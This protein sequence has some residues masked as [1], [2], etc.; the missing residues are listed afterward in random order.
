MSSQAILDYL[1]ANNAVLT[2]GHFVFTSGNH[3]SAYINMRAVAHHSSW[4]ASVGQ[5]LAHRLSKYQPDLILGPETLGR[6]LAG[7][8]AQWICPEGGI[9]CDI[10]DIGN[11]KLGVWRGT[12]GFNQLVEGK[13]V[14]IVD[15]LLTT[16]S[17]IKASSLLVTLSG[18][19][20]VAAAAVVRRSPEVTA[21]DCGAPAL[22]VLAE[23]DG[24]AIYTPEACQ[25]Y[26]PCSEQMPMRLR[27]G[28]GWRWIE[29]NPDYPVYE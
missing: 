7:Y 23:V 26:G 1:A 22:E 5:R 17:S 13:R 24:F 28:H 12:L 8:T 4:M 10:S 19:E 15:D 14:A 27:P 25:S 3:G 18:G 29:S 21:A 20:V 6:T 16:G 2:G 11:E 9:W